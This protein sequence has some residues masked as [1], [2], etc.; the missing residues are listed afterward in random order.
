[1]FT[2]CFSSIKSGESEDVPEGLKKILLKMYEDWSSLTVHLQSLGTTA[3]SVLAKLP[4]EDAKLVVASVVKNVA[5]N[6]GL[7]TEAKPSVLTN[8][9]EINW[10][11]EVILIARII[12]TCLPYS[13]SCRSFAM[14]CR[15]R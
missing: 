7:T 8:E 4:P 13:D 11:M 1:M 12:K 9:T 2:L 3:Q 10:F 6:L 5:S 15:S 14:V